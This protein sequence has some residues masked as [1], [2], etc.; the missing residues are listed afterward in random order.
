MAA[1]SDTFTGTAGTAL[2]S[3][4][5]DTGETW[6][7]HTS[8]GSGT[9]DIRNNQVRGSAT[10]ALFW[11]SWTPPAADYYVEITLDVLDTGSPD[12]PGASG[13]IDTAANTHYHARYSRISAGAQLFKFV[14]GTATQLGSTFSY[15]PADGDTIRLDMAG[16][17]IRLLI[18]G[19][20][21][22]SVTDSAI[23]ATG[24]AG[25]R[26][27]NNQGVADRVH[28]ASLTADSAAVQHALAGT[29][30]GTSTDAGDLAVAHTLAGSSAGTST[31]T[32][33]AAV[34]HTLAGQSAGTSTD[35][36]DTAATFA[37]AGSSDG[38]ST[39]LADL[40]ALLSLAA[41]SDGESS[42]TATL[43]LFYDLAGTTAGTSTDTATLLSLIG[44][45]AT[46]DGE[47]SDTAALA[48][49]RALTAASNGTSTDTAGLAVL[50]ILAGTD[51]GASTD[52]GA[53]RLDLA[54]A[55]ISAG[56][57][58]DTAT[59]AEPDIVDLHPLA[60]TLREHH[61]VT[62][63]EDHALILREHH[64]LA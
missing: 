31:D 25:L 56:A 20:E 53:V 52:I 42:D 54:F 21:R 22:I 3:H 64:H 36:G 41:T 9:A 8:L 59:L 55:G 4:T 39:D 5:A 26:W 12:T 14:A 17:T 51:A 1:L 28:I 62:V 7:K 27:G 63:T 10:P 34:A 6:T 43:A 24:K 57:S 49:L 37:L 33:D 16:T 19:V 13:R 61:Q 29:S 44:L 48:A 60:I 32:G 47:S 45:A 40:A 46:S 23:T 2:E 35:I 11:S 15:T 50:F 58:T 30:A 18:N 38:T